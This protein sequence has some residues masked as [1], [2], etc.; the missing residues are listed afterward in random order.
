MPLALLPN[1]SG[2]GVSLPDYEIFEGEI[3]LP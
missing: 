2:R 3:N 1:L